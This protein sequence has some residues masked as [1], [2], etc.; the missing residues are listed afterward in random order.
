M[1]G[2]APDSTGA[3]R[4]ALAVRHMG[5]GASPVLALHCG[6]GVSAMW[7]GVAAHLGPDVR[8][9]APDLPG[10]GR[11]APFPEGKD[12]HDA[13]FAAI[14]PLLDQPMHLVGHSFGATIALRMALAAPDRVLSLTLIEPV[15]FAAAPDSPI[16]QAHR[17]AEEH[18][19]EVAETGDLLAG[20]EVFNS[21]W[22]GGV[23]WHSFKPE[24]QKD[25]AGRMPFVIATEPSLW[26]D[27]AGMLAPGG[28]ERLAMPVRLI[29]GSRSV[30]IITEVH[31]GLLARLPNAN[32][33]VIDGAAHML[34][35]T[36]AEAVAG[37]MTGVMTGVIGA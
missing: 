10:H 21:L 19:F 33:Q 15:F 29:R 25:M 8:I 34:V 11:S 30:P 7:K 35:M 24:V 27:R 16:K 37:V 4:P 3:E 26:Q 1:D 28:L 12:V 13:A 5:E 14:S 17:R 6:L 18:F 22:G 31:K 36:H 32:E 2:P 23:P 9:T 20:A